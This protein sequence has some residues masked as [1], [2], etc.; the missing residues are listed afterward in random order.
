MFVRAV[1]GSGREGGSN[2]HTRRKFVTACLARGCFF[3][4]SCRLARGTTTLRH[5]AHHAFEHDCAAGKGDGIAGFDPMRGF[6][7]FIIEVDFSATDRIGR[8]GTGF[9][10][11]DCEQPAVDPRA[12]IR[13]S[14]HF[15]SLTIRPPPSQSSRVVLRA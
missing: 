3:V 14:R 2:F 13:K 7:T 6:H 4:G 9:E 5:C 1:S 12:Y 10:Q 15:S 11:A 8:G